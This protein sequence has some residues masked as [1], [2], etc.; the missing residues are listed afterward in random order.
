MHSDWP[1]AAAWAR[2]AA[3]APLSTAATAAERTSA[4]RSA[5]RIAFPLRSKDLTP[6]IFPQPAC[7]PPAV[8]ENLARLLDAG[9]PDAQHLLVGQLVEAAVL[10]VAGHLAHRG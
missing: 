2:G 7:S 10:A 8:L 9:G 1:P 6:E 4:Q 5:G 3:A